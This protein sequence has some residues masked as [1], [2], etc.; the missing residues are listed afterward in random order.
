MLLN[1]NEVAE[2]FGVTPSAVSGW[3]RRGCP[4]VSRGGRGRAWEFD[5]AEVVR[6]RDERRAA[7]GD[8]QLDLA[9]E[10][11]QLARA[12]RIKTEQETRVRAG[13]LVLAADVTRAWQAMVGAV[14]ARL[15]GLPSGAAPQVA[16]EE[17]PAKCR[18][19]LK[20]MV[21]ECLEE[22]GGNG[23]P[24]RV[25]DVLDGDE[26]DLSAAAGSD[27]Q[28]VGGRR[29]AAQRRRKRKAG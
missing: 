2:A 10:R 8:G 5:L 13:E 24:E 23:L 9:Q 22:L 14:R 29:K 17:S 21:R 25:A 12:Q 27:G 18:A 1:R 6:W 4:V 3:V 15:L 7:E 26:G 28:P 11:A 16:A 20:E 19:I